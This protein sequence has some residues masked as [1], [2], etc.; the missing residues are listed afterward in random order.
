MQSHFNNTLTPPDRVYEILDR[1]AA[2]GLDIKIT[3]FDINSTDE[4]A[5]ADYTRD[6]LTICFSHPAVKGF[7]KWGFWEGRHWRPNAAMFRRDW[8]EKPNAQAWRDLIY[9][10]W[11]TTADGTT[12]EEGKYAVRAFQGT[13]AVEVE[14]GGR[15]R[16]QTITLGAEGAV[17]KMVLE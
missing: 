17:V 11:W 12:G 1:F 10:D 4:A 2:L 15:A 5:Q 8:S 14:H 7:Y 16:R 6:Y 13:H 9:K 3:E